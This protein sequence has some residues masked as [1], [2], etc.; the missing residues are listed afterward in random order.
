MTWIVTTAWKESKY[1]VFS[2]P[3]YPALGKYGP[4]K[5]PYLETFYA[6]YYLAGTSCGTENFIM[7]F[8]RIPIQNSGQNS[9]YITVIIHWQP[10]N[11]WF[12]WKE[13]I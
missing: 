10:S 11:Q 6:V 13:R 1:V 4:E 3:Y 2:S 9:R 5:S 8:L 7:F 12:L